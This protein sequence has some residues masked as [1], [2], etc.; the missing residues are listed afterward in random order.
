MRKA[1]K[2]IALLFTGLFALGGFSACDKKKEPRPVQITVM[3]YNIRMYNMRTIGTG[4][5]DDWMVREPAL[6]AQI[7]EASPDLLGLEEAYKIQNDAISEAFPEYDKVIRYRDGFQEINM[8]ESSPI[9]YKRD[10]FELLS[11]GVFWLS[12][13]PDVMSK[14]WDG[15]SF[16]ICTYARFREK[17]NGREFSYFNTHMDNVGETARR[18]GLKLILSRIALETVPVILTGDLNFNESDENYQV[19]TAVLQDSK[20]KA[21]DTMSAGTTPSYRTEDTSNGSPIDF[22]FT[23]FSGFNIISYRVLTGKVNGV[24]ASDHYPVKVVLELI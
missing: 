1:T 11:E 21:P 3:V 20:Y 22:C 16:R 23:S 24:W 2:I 12:E 18:E 14:G 19:V 10:K 5:P 4:D 7:G 8:S 13:T 6:L 9:F 15:G 17:S